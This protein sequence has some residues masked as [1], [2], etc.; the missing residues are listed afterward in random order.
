ML[1]RSA[2]KMGINDI[3]VPMNASIGLCA[4]RIWRWRAGMREGV[5]VHDVR[6]YFRPGSVR[7][8]NLDLVTDVGVVTSYG[9]YVLH[10]SVWCTS[11]G[12]RAIYGTEADLFPGPEDAGT[13]HG[14][15]IP[16]DL[17]V[18]GGMWEG[19]MVNNVR[20]VSIRDSG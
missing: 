1:V 11:Y 9:V 13:W 10:T 12:L 19:V 4:Y 2:R 5:M 3:V 14:D 6:G 8:G 15:S 18:E 17:E 20:G 7:F 16:E